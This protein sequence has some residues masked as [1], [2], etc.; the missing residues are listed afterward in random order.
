[1]PPAPTGEPTV[2][3]AG[4]HAVLLEVTDLGQVLALDALLREAVERGDG[5]W[6][7]VTDVV[8]AA[9][10]VLLLARPGTDLSALAAA[11][12]GLTPSD[13]RGPGP[14]GVGTGH[15]PREVEIGVRYN[16][17][18]LDEV[19]GL[20]GLTP[21]EV[22]LAHTR[23]PWRVAFGGF[24]P[25]FGYLVGGDPRLRVPRRRSPRPTVPAGSVALAGEF[26]GVYPRASPGGWQLI[27]TT[28]A[29]LW[30]PDRVPPALLTPGST[31]RFVDVAATL[32]PGQTP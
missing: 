30:D 23:M 17:A 8:P 10:T 11:A 31:V 15:G 5:P 1:M 4:P 16:G 27:G 9:R 20:T 3:P 28:D 7:T 26:T 22:A 25:G 29:V 14:H 12:R 21:A 13:V 6:A 19:A 18:D 24:V 32:E 2:L